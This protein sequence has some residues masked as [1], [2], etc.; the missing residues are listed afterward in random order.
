[1]KGVLQYMHMNQQDIKEK[2]REFLQGHRKAVFA[3]VDAEGR[4]H[5]SLMLYVI[6]DDMNV[7]FGTR[8]AFNKYKQLCDNPAISLS[9]IQES[10]DPLQVVDIYGKAEPLPDEEREKW[11]AYFK[12]HNPSVYYVEAAE[13]YVM[14][15]IQPEGMRW[16]DATSGELVI[17]SIEV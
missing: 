13:D 8:K 5:T 6:D 7:Y 17:E 12:D 4:P 3:T 9:I 16:L 10:V 15:R 14:F 1:M 2:A 11:F